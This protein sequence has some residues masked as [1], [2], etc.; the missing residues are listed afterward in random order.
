[1]S[2]PEFFG[3]LAVAVVGVFLV[4]LVRGRPLFGDR[5]RVLSMV[6]LVVSGVSFALLAFHCAA[7]F[8]AGSVAAV[9]VL[10]A[11]AAVVSDL[12]DPVGRVAYWVPA[13][14]LVIAFRR[15]WW[16]APA[17][18]GLALV[19]VG[20][21]MY[22]GSFTV[23]QHLATI[24]VSLLGITLTIAAL[25][26]RPWRRGTLGAGLLDP[27]DLRE[28]TSDRVDGRGGD[29]NTVVGSRSRSPA[30]PSRAAPM[31]PT[32]REHRCTPSRTC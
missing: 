31:G 2:H 8:A 14:T 6:E 10:D 15:L 28:A 30:E 25:V 29:E 13:V 21:T 5:A 23:E 12:G 20:G 19:A 4:R 3:P 22:Y 24:A 27:P 32:R 16:P 11:P 1:M 7:M 26:G 17:G 18:L 9:G